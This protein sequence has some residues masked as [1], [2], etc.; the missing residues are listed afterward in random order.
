MCLEEINSQ[1]PG[2]AHPISPLDPTLVHPVHP[3]CI[4]RW[5]TGEERARRVPRCPED[6]REIDL[7]APAL[8]RKGEKWKHRQW[9]AIIVASGGVGGMVGSFAGMTALRV[10]D[11]L[12]ET[13]F[14]KGLLA[15]GVGWVTSAAVMFIVAEGLPP[16]IPVEAELGNGILGGLCVGCLVGTSAAVGFRSTVE[17][18]AGVVMAIVGPLQRCLGARDLV[19]LTGIVSAIAM[20][21][22]LSESVLLPI[23]LGGMSIPFIA[24]DFLM[25][26][27]SWEILR[28]N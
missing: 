24:N 10:A 9:M 21:G 8:K 22:R 28:Y 15:G 27:R 14:L 11:G 17:E 25:P 3:S 18:T 4:H 19:A 20:M 13:L 16:D 5:I 23:V 7:N 26:V 1:H 12:F 2:L 6:R